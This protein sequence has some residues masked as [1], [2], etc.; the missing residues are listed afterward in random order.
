[1]VVHRFLTE[2]LH[3]LLHASMI[4]PPPRYRDVSILSPF[5]PLVLAHPPDIFL[6]F[7]P[8]QNIEDKLD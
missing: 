5:N 8:H 6:D 3:L 7:F 2:D 4:L 1:M